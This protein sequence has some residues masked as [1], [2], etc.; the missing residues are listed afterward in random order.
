MGLWKSKDIRW[1]S[2]GSVGRSGDI[3]MCW[4]ESKFACTST[5]NIG[6]AVVVNGWWKVTGYDLY[7]I[8][9]YAPCNRDEKS[10]LW[11]RLSLV[12]AQAAGS[13]LCAI[14]DF[15]SIIEEGERAGSG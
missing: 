5:W 11:D 2:E 13:H 10:S 9:V 4:D 6:G 14:G 1:S 8:N 15:N 3:L 12:V 7:L